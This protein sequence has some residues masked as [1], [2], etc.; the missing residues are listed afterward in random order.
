MAERVWALSGAPFFV[1]VSQ[2]PI[3]PAR[4]SPGRLLPAVACMPGTPERQLHCPQ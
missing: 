3:T 4:A 2:G 1:P